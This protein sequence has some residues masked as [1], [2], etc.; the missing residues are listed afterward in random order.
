M[1][2]ELRDYRFYNEDMLHP[3]QLAINYIWERFV[4]VN[5]SQDT[6]RVMMSIDA[7]QKSMSHRPFNP[8]S[9]A[10]QVFLE[11]LDAKKKA[12]SSLFPHLKF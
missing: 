2:D 7:I 10:H 3:S 6:Q 4:A 12:V 5:V 1:M 8:K 9:K 11:E